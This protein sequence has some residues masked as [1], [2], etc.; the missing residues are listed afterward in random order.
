MAELPSNIQEFNTV[1]AL[2]FGQ[3]YKAFPVRVD[4]INREGIAEAMGFGG[5]EWATH[6]L[7]SGRTLSEV[8]AYTISWLNVENYIH[9]SGSHP[10]EN[11]TLTTKGLSALNAMPPGLGQSVGSELADKAEK[12]WRAD[13]NS[14]GDL[15]GG[16]IGGATKSLTSG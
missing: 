10:A 8:M 16:I 3:L 12:G 5:K 9:A 14:I 4:L 7:P 2:V 6:K 15:I 11:V 1:A 13:F